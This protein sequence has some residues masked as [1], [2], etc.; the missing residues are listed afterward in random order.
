MHHF[1]SI[2][3]AGGSRRSRWASVPWVSRDCA[4]LLSATGLR[5]AGAWRPACSNSSSMMSWS[6]GSAPSPPGRGQ[7]GTVYPANVKIGLA[8]QCRTIVR[9]TSLQGHYFGEAHRKYCASLLKVRTDVRLSQGLCRVMATLHRTNCG[10]KGSWKRMLTIRSH[11]IAI[12]V[13]AV[14]ASSMAQSG[15]KHY[16][17]GASDTEIK[18]GNIIP[19]SV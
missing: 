16:D 2:A 3:S 14:A 5:R 9:K 4:Q 18:V 8:L 1:S 6:S 10:S 13:A 19:Y 15:E 11:S 17:V 7:C 12:T